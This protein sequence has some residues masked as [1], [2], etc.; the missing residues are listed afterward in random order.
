LPACVWNGQSYTNLLIGHGANS[1]G[2]RFLA[3]HLVTFDFPNRTLYL[4]QT[5][6]NPLLSERTLAAVEFLRGL[7]EKSQTPGWSTNDDGG[8]DLEACPN[9]K[10]YV[11]RR[12][13]IS[14]ASHYRITRASDEGPWKL[15]KAWRTDQND[16][17]IEEYRVP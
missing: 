3:R 14:S 5:T 15:Q 13:G 16:H 8:I 9:F 6:G 12:S 11:F 2:L 1:I 4:K 10:T 7:N 17:T